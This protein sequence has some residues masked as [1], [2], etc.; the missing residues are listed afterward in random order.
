MLLPVAPLNAGL[1]H[2]GQ[3]VRWGASLA[4]SAAFT[5][6]LLLFLQLSINL[7]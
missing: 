6:A 4:L 3:I 7:A 2:G 5:A 1:G